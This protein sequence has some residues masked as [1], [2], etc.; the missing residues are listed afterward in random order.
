MVNDTPDV[1]AI[2]A[3]VRAEV[4]AQRQALRYD[5]DDSANR[6][7]IER[8]L[9][10]C[11]EQ[12]EITRVV[13]AHWPLQGRTFYERSWVWVHKLVR[14]YLR[15]YINPIVEQQNEFNDVTARTLRLLIEAYTELRAQVAELE[16]ATAQ[17]PADDPGML[18]IDHQPP[19]TDDQLSTGDSATLQ[20]TFHALQARVE[21]R[22]RAEPPVALADVALRPLATQLATHQT[23]NAHWPLTGDTLI[24]QVRALTQRVLRQYLRWL[25]NPIVEQQNGYNAAVTET[26]SPLR[27][28]DAELR[29]RLA[30]LRAG[31]V[32]R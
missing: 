17:P 5:D 8:Q 2:L 29:F 14:R 19:A 15:W 22:G 28:V 20:Y 7:A 25:I 21:Q 6:S 26:V 4:H 24:G 12:L 27:S 3:Q 16:P 1:A 18:T 11:V 13:S 32:R 9:K 31:R 23:V 30:A 10:R